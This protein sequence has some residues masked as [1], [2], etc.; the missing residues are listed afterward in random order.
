MSPGA[1]GRHRRAHQPKVA[2]R[3]PC[4]ARRRSRA[5]RALRDGA[6]RCA[7]FSGFGRVLS[8]RSPC[9]TV[10]SKG[11]GVAG[12]G[13]LTSLGAAVPGWGA[14]TWGGLEGHRV[15][16]GRD[17]AIAEARL[18]VPPRVCRERV[19]RRLRRLQRR[20]PAGGAAAADDDVRA[21]ARERIV[22]W[23]HGREVSPGASAS[24]WQSRLAELCLASITYT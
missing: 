13:T 8:G 2:P 22:L 21:E 1:H 10:L 5:R 11:R 23:G 20:P 15:A 16:Q 6:V 24:V 12:A 19:V 3:P 9:V 18:P 17:Q 14:G 7:R 4:C